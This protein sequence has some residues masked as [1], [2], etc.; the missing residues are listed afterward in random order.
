MRACANG[1]GILEQVGEQSDAFA[2]DEALRV[3]FC[4]TEDET[5]WVDEKLDLKMK[6]TRNAR[7]TPRRRNLWLRG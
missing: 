7:K 1:L 5:S 2:S 4:E 6:I 3:E